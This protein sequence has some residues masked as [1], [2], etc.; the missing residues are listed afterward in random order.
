MKEPALVEVRKNPPASA[1]FWRIAPAA[2]LVALPFAPA[3]VSVKNP[4]AGLMEPVREFV[5]WTPKLVSV[6]LLTKILVKSRNRLLLDRTSSPLVNEMAGVLAAG[7]V[8]SA[9]R[10]DRM[11]VKPL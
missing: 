10:R 5:G 4:V 11:L 1:V 6:L 8:Q 2:V 7:L 3:K 9:P